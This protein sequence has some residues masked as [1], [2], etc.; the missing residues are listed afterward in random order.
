MVEHHL[1]YW[2]LT[3]AF[4]KRLVLRF[5]E[6][7]EES[8]CLEMYV[9]TCVVMIVVN[10]RAEIGSLIHFL[11]YTYKNNIYFISKIIVSIGTRNYAT[12]NCITCCL[13]KSNF[14]MA[15]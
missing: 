11:F 12:C 13:K 8:D 3:N 14:R 15:G 10:K 6:E 1:D 2:I 4:T 5:E 7:E 9:G